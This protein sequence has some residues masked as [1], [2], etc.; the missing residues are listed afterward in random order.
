LSTDDAIGEAAAAA[1]WY[2]ERSSS[3]AIGFAD[4]IDTAITAIERNPE[5]WPSYDHGTRHC[6]LRRYPFSVEATKILVVAVAHGHRRP[7]PD[8]TGARSC[9][10]LARVGIVSARVP[11]VSGNVRP[12]QN[13]MTIVCFEGPIQ[14]VR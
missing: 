13:R 8:G 7:R 6:L 3:A 10:R 11:R 14:A 1:R 4:E 2:A 12:L 9:V 5:A